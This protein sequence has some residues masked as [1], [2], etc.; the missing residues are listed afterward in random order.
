MLYQKISKLVLRLNLFK[1]S[2]GQTNQIKDN[3]KILF[4][5]SSYF[6]NI[7]DLPTAGCLWLSTEFIFVFNPMDF[8]ES[9]MW[10]N[11]P[12]PL[13]MLGSNWTLGI[14]PVTDA[15]LDPGFA[16]FRPLFP[17]E[18]SQIGKRGGPQLS[19]LI[20]TRISNLSWVGITRSFI[21]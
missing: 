19:L 13:F 1:V 3:L 10:N 20:Y 11:L 14:V 5:P 9:V 15:N 6:C 8:A 7:L 2:W 18:L 12:P 4:K 17:D 21:Y 16:R